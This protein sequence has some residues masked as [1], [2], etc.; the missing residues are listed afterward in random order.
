MNFSSHVSALTSRIPKI[1]GSGARSGAA[2][3]RIAS[4]TALTMV[5]GLLVA[6]A[7]SAEGFPISKVDLNDGSVWVTKDNEGILGR[8]NSQVKELDL[9]VVTR[10]AESDLHQAGSDVQIIDLGGGALKRIMVVDVAGGAAGKA[11]EL[12]KTVS[13]SAGRRTIALVD[14]QSGQG[15][16]TS[17]D[18][19]AGFTV[20]ETPAV[21][22][23]G[24][25]SSVIVGTDGTAYF[26]NRADGSVIPVSTDANGLSVAGDAVNLDAELGDV[27]AMTVV[28]AKPVVLDRASSTIYRAGGD[29][30][31]IDDGASAQLQQPQ[32]SQGAPT[33]FYVATSAGM[34]R[35]DVS[36][37]D[38]E[39]VSTAKV[40]GPPA[41]P[42]VVAGCAY[43][44]WLDPA[45]DENFERVCG[46]ETKAQKIPRLGAN[47]E[48]VFR[49]NREVVVLNDASGG[50]AWMV[51]AG[52]EIVDNW[53]VVDPRKKQEQEEVKKTKERDP[54][55]NE[56]PKAKDDKDFGA[57]AGTTVVLPV[58]VNDTDPDGDILTV[59]PNLQTDNSDVKLS[60][61][62][63]GTQVQARV[64][65]NVRGEVRFT[66]AVTDG[67]PDHAESEAEV[68]LEVAAGDK[69]TKPK[70]F[71]ERTN[72]LTVAKGHESQVNVLP[73]WFDPEG[74]SLVLTAASSKNGDVRFRPDGTITFTD[75][76]KGS[77][78]KSIA[79]TLQGGRE[80]V[81]AKV[82]VSVVDEKKAAPVTVPDRVTGV[83]GSAILI[84]PLTNDSNPL[85]DGTMRLTRV[86]PQ[87]A[88]SGDVQV[89][90]DGDK[91]TGSVRASKPGSY[92]L[93]YVA[94]NESASAKPQVIRVDAIAVGRVNH[95]PVAEKD[96]ANL[97]SG[98]T[99]LVDVLAND[100]DPDGDVLVVQGF[101]QIPD[102]I[103]ASLVDKQFVRVESVVPLDGQ[104]EITYHLSDGENQVDG[105]ITVSESEGDRN[106][107]PVAQNDQFAARAGTIITVPVLAN[108]SDPDGDKLT[109]YGQD[110][111]D[112]PDD[113]A[114]IATGSAIRIQVPDDGRTELEFGYTTHDPEL[115]GASARVVLNISPDDPKGNQAPRPGPIEDRTISGQKVRIPISAYNSDPDGDP[116]S[117]TAIAQQPELGRIVKTGVDWIEYEPFDDAA[118][119]D[120]FRI[121]VSDKYG[122]TGRA[123]VRVGVAP[124]EAVNQAPTALDDELFVR[125]DRTI[126]FAVRDNDT[127][128]DGDGFS[129]LPDV[130]SAPGVEASVQGDFVE[131]KSLPLD[132][133]SERVATAQYAV[134]DRL[135]GESRA[136]LSVTSSDLAP[137]H[138]PIAND[139]TV[140][141]SEIAGKKPGDT[142]SVDVLDNDGDID[143]A[144]SDLSFEPLGAGTS[145]DGKFQATLTA[146]DQ[147]V[148]YRLTDR[149]DQV[150]FGFVYISGTDSFAPVLDQDEVP[151]EVT[152]GELKKIDLRQII[153]VRDGHEPVIA[154][155]DEISVVNGDGKTETSTDEQTLEF[156]SLK[157]YY[158]PAAMLLEVT[159]GA[160]LNDP[161]GLVSQITVPIDVL[162]AGNVAPIVRSTAV[163]VAAGGDAV[164]IDL[165]RLAEDPNGD[166]LTFNVGD[167]S[168]GV[169]GDV[170]G[171]TLKVKANKDAKIGDTIQLTVLVDDGHVKKPSQ[172]TVQVRVVDSTKPLMTLVSPISVEGKAGEPVTIDLTD[173][174]VTDPFPKDAKKVSSQRVVAGDGAVRADGTTLVV[175]PAKDFDGVLA[176]GFRMDDGSG[177]ASR[178]VAGRIEVTV[179]D[180]PD[181][182]GR[183]SSAADGPEA[184][185]LSWSAPDDNGKP[186]TEYRVT[187]NGGDK[188]CDGTQCLID[189]LDPG[190]EYVFTV[191]ARNAVDWSKESA[192]SAPVTPDEVPEQM[193]A[194]TIDP[195]TTYPARDGKLE[196]A[197]TTPD[198]TGSAIASYEVQQSPGSAKNFGATTLKSTFG[199][200]ANGTEYK[201]RARA[202]ND[203]GEGAWSNWSESATPFSKPGVVNGVTI[204]ADPPD[205]SG[206]GHVNASW[207][208]PVDDGGDPDSISKYTVEVL[209]DGSV[210]A[211]KTTTG[212]STDFTV[213]NGKQY[214]V[215]VK[216]ENSAGI[217]D[218]WV[219]SDQV[220]VYDKSN[221]P[222]NLTNTNDGD[223][224][225]TLRFT[226]PSD[227]GG[228]PV[229]KYKVAT[230]DGNSYTVNAP[231]S[232]KSA[233]TTLEITFNDNH[234]DGQWVRIR[235]VT[236]PPGEGDVDGAAAQSGGVFR[237][238]GNPGAPASNGSSAGY[239]ETTVRWNGGTPNGRPIESTEYS[240]DASGT[241][242]A[243][244]GSARI[245][246][247]Q[248]GQSRCVQA[249]SRAGGLWSSWSVNI[250]GTA[251]AR[252]VT[253]TY[254]GVSGSNG[255]CNTSCDALDV[256]VEGFKNASG[257]AYTTNI[258]ASDGSG[259]PSGTIPSSGNGRGSKQGVAYYNRDVY[260]AR[261]CVTVDGETGC[262]NGR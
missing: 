133:A 207:N 184:V 155:R 91:G 165:D 196:V 34:Y 112:L 245:D 141:L 130:T 118:G 39:Q 28:G 29:A 43:G 8:L 53:D 75:D 109:V 198:N 189:G 183:P 24:Q 57:R 136:T 250:C 103:K 5:A 129:L 71:E 69:D 86:E 195:T 82:D 45:A 199:S 161:D 242:G 176:V 140:P 222:T 128:P 203:K 38:L 108:D 233:T 116:V 46:G 142:V 15:W 146:E 97:V 182:P 78:N 115:A 249:R 218:E 68:V 50:N 36:G 149:D 152:A 102:G 166:D 223:R 61:V 224:K 64:G 110:L 221:A 145:V 122:A 87:A 216:A 234:N 127:D 163:S 48:L 160:N 7:V 157:K 19:V 99:A 228:F 70:K 251:D 210:T 150:S 59:S 6:L 200:L 230:Q 156:R 20:K 252:K 236:Q 63:N 154:R 37:G 137:F 9:G 77:S 126:Q 214:S 253:V 243:S 164:E 26:L 66:Y 4:G 131:L 256:A 239:R 67:Q 93:E 226:T 92:Y 83:A 229:K 181:R 123:D 23:L 225:G 186:I 180:K 11:V 125:P 134:T 95:P 187:W 33:S 188:S 192:K 85:G 238:F 201:F 171:S 212:T 185:R 58:T 32:G 12:P 197:W 40:S 147:V 232:S 56:P 1:G 54:N 55:K 193:A 246:T 138:A 170:S 117:F 172:G 235:P 73:A 240:G 261:Y 22:G 120:A 177:L 105:S 44:A 98:N 72:E 104:A 215:R 49:V 62:G 191:A 255:P 248:G 143:G 219:T 13:V 206:D 220:T 27:V 74:D 208:P 159:D 2:S 213:A 35:G 178:L 10:A 25:K 179:A 80:S 259:N 175:T 89:S 17:S 132:G 227:D 79:F 60:V 168:K 101:G 139:D 84:D 119:T 88:S 113:V 16:V 260:E 81:K 96:T 204:T 241:A 47:A 21:E 76:G 41:A 167:G 100:S 257:Y 262:V 174:I 42:V 173:Q 90:F 31:Q 3:R 14:S 51:Q 205:G 190:T 194:P 153:N 211:S 52:M 244:G 94:A 135:G 231:T 258:T 144:K 237:P 121:E 247:D 18:S 162:P 209:G 202:V 114:V 65:S 151:I 124:R 169:S 217:A 158:G 30:V 107:P 148:A 111:T 254:R 106:R